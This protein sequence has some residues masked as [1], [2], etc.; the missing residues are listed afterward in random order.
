MQTNQKNRSMTRLMRLIVVAF[1]LFVA[2]FDSH[3]DEGFY[4]IKADDGAKVAN[5][6]IPVELESRIEIL[7][8]IVIAGNPNGKVTLT[9]FYDLNC[10]YCRK[11]SGDIA[12][13]VR[14]NP[15]LRLVL[16]PFPVFGIPSILVARV[17]YA[18]ARL[19]PP[20]K[21]YQFHRVVFAGHGVVDDNRA[22]EA[23][24]AI[25]FDMEK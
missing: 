19:A 3:A 7:P 8:G 20:Q 9:E 14:T 10:P 5:H 21:F 13:L 24:N 17:E 15:E 25:G 11:A 12:E 6:R 1:I 4:P 18:V 22:F 2:P 23:A 16:V